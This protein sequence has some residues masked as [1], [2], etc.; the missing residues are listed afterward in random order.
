EGA[1]YG[2]IKHVDHVE[3]GSPGAERDY[4]I[5]DIETVPTPAYSEFRENYVE[6]KEIGIDEALRK[7]VLIQQD[8]SESLPVIG[9]IA[10]HPEVYGEK[11]FRQTDHSFDFV[12]D[13][14]TIGEI[15]QEYDLWSYGRS[16]AFD[17][18][19]REGENW[20]LGLIP[21]EQPVFP[22]D[23]T[24]DIVI[25]SEDF[26]SRRTVET[27]HGELEVLPPEVQVASKSKRLVDRKVEDDEVRYTD[28]ADI[29]NMM[30]RNA[31][32]G[33][34]YDRQVLSKYMENYTNGMIS[35][36]GWRE[37]IRT[38]LEPNLARNEIESLEEEMDRI[39]KLLE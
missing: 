16:Y 19:C 5:L 1:P 15:S 12:A 28:P 2:W 18:T 22:A 35:D 7:N 11:A 38:A 3:N 10:A 37:E 33:E 14:E 13:L 29:G 9:S 30:L 4:S 25:E 39:E 21:L 20:A 24:G 36:I 27:R 26:E 23:E 8:F 31:R 17:Y 32:S 6:G 34:L